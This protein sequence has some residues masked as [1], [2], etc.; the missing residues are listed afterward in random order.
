MVIRKTSH[1][2]PSRL[3]H[4]AQR[5]ITSS[6]ILGS[7]LKSS[8][9]AQQALSCPIKSID[10]ARDVRYKLKKRWEADTPRASD[11]GPS[12]WRCF[13]MAFMMGMRMQE[14]E[15]CSTCCTRI[16]AV[17]GPPGGCNYWQVCGGD[18][19]P[20]SAT[21]WFAPTVWGFSIHDSK[22]CLLTSAASRACSYCEPVCIYMHI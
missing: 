6:Y 19:L 18:R 17:A 11:D 7:P 9:S 5:N 14:L 22:P 2:G 16:Y 4:T 20:L 3:Q 15:A 10:R 8:I 12:I 21:E 1:T 13:L